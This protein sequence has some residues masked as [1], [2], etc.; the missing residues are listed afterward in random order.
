M[1]E[2]M[3]PFLRLEK[4]W[5]EH[6]QIGG[7]MPLAAGVT[8]VGRPSEGDDIDGKVHHVRVADEHVSRGHLSI[9]YDGSKKRFMLKEKEGGTPKGTFVKTAGADNFI[10]INKGELRPLSDGDLIG[11]ARVGSHVRVIF[12]FRDSEV[13][14]ADA[15]EPIETATKR[16]IIDKV[17]RLVRID[18]K[19]VELGPMEFE[20]LE[21]LHQNLNK[22]CTRSQIIKQVWLTRHKQ[23]DEHDLDDTVYRI[24]KAIKKALK[25]KDGLIRTKRGIGYWLEL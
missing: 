2:K 23:V 10:R 9:Y 8:I 16:I 7:K 6:C 20:V 21:L 13:T 22:V 17:G 19:V 18:G 3:V 5:V 24:R 1:T 12:R 4:G 15:P 11:L 14:L 25:S